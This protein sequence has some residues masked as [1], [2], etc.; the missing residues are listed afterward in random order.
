[1]S[2]ISVM[3]DEHRHDDYAFRVPAGT[4]ITFDRP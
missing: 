1:L 3:A 4:D 2:A